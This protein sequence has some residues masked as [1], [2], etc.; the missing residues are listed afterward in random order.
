M[1]ALCGLLYMCSLYGNNFL[2]PADLWR[3]DGTGI[4]IFSLT[5]S[6]S[7]FQF[8]SRSLNFDDIKTRPARKESDKLAQVR[9]GLV[10]GFNEL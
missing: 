7:R 4:E 5:M 6:Y 3:T 9:K 1:R 10:S 8:L 2:S